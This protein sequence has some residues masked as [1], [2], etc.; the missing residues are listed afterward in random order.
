MDRT[1]ALRPR[2]RKMKTPKPKTRG[3]KSLLNAKL[4]RQICSLLAAGNTIRTTVDAVG[5]SQ[6]VYFEWCERHPHFAQATS[7]ARGKARVKLVKVLV[8]ASALDW[9][10]AAWLLSHCWPEDFS[11]N[12]IPERPPQPELL[13]PLEF[14][15]EKFSKLLDSL[16]PLNV[17]GS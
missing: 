9:K 2:R 3:R 17:A 10:S 1:K 8:D 7:R 16:P 13:P 4:Q 5:I 14:S 6:R 11:E 12:R 15:S